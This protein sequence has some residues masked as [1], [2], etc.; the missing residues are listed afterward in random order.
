MGFPKHPKTA[1]FT[2]LSVL[3]LAMQPVQPVQ[4]DPDPENNTQSAQQS[5]VTV[6]ESAEESVAD[7]ESEHSDATMPWLG[8]LQAGETVHAQLDAI[9][10]SGQVKLRLNTDGLYRFLVRG[11]GPQST[12]LALQMMR[13]F[14]GPII[15]HDLEGDY[16][17][18]S[19][20]FRKAGEY[21]I[22][23]FQINETPRYMDLELTLEHIQPREL[24]ASVEI[25]G[26]LP[27]GSSSQFFAIKHYGGDSMQLY[28][29]GLENQRNLQLLVLQPDGDMI[30]RDEDDNFNPSAERIIFNDLPGGTYY[31]EVRRRD[32]RAISSDF[33]IAYVDAATNYF[34][35]AGEP[36]NH[37]TAH[38]TERPSI[39]NMP[40][41][42]GKDLIPGR[43]I[44]ARLDEEQSRVEHK[45][46]VRE[47][48][49]LVE[50]R[51]A[52]ADLMLLVEGPFR[53]RADFD[54]G[55]EQGHEFVILPYPG[56][57]RIIV[58]YSSA[59]RIIPYAYQIRA[60]L[61]LAHS[62]NAGQSLNHTVNL[63]EARLYSFRVTHNTPAVL[64]V[65][66]T[67]PLA[68]SEDLLLTVYTRLP[69]GTID[70]RNLDSDLNGH[71]AYERVT[72][73]RPCEIYVVVRQ[74]SSV[75][76]RISYQIELNGSTI[77]SS[78]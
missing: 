69:D 51:A 30:V 44:I 75:A 5:P 12:D 7:I 61:T 21:T 68:D 42:A 32:R 53:Y 54:A 41:H 8:A 63:Q 22:Q 6:D 78:P 73:G 36:Q 37:H 48:P 60:D 50:V 26:D 47:R 13:P 34:P 40:V 29:Q 71:T 23:I 24:S 72:I 38:P 66:G 55:K 16:R 31:I 46:V 45:V 56:E 62:L 67:G 57:Y 9:N 39:D 28:V 11:Q 10:H 20:L 14:R 52:E 1:L 64:D 59:A 77:L 49:V 27:A 76:K 74:G 70:V 15:D 35:P 18:E 2:L 43:A 58:Q 3:V 17:I 25:T 4:A 33:K 65:R 19:M